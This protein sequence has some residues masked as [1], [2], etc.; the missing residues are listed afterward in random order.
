M[1]SGNRMSETLFF[2]NTMLQLIHRIGLTECTVSQ[3]MVLGPIVPKSPG[4]FIKV[5][6]FLILVLEVRAEICSCK[7]VLGQ[8]PQ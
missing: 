4:V 7:S 6:D 8:I 1:D 2:F 3:S 5:K